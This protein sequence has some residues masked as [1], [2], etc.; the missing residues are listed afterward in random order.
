MK[1]SPEQEKPVLFLADFGASMKSKEQMNFNLQFTQEYWAPELWLKL[2]PFPTSSQAY[3]S[4]LDNINKQGFSPQASFDTY[5]M[6]LT[7]YYM[8]THRHLLK[9]LEG[10]KNI[11][12]P[13]ELNRFLQ[14][15][16]TKDP[17]G[18]F[19]KFILVSIEVFVII[20]IKIYLT[21]LCSKGK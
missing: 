20:I 13:E 21:V 17:H 5:A 2:K 7:V 4:H 3:L 8:C 12:S 19:F 10:R 11:I 6:G 18:F 15:F 1:H 16:N 9:E 14:N